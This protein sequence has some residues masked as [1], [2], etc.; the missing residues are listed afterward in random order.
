M[1]SINLSIKKI[2]KFILN[3]S[4]KKKQQVIGFLID[5]NSLSKNPELIKD[6]KKA[7]ENIQVGETIT[8][9]NSKNMWQSIL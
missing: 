5:T 6:V 4:K 7:E 3:L 9:A 2:I 1:N 8:I